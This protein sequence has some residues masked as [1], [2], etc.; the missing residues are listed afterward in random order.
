M[1]FFFFI[2]A[3]NPVN[4]TISIFVDGKEV[5]A[6][7][8]ILQ[9]RY[10]HCIMT[11]YHFST[12]FRSSHFWGKA[13][14]H[15]AFSWFPSIPGALGDRDR[16]QGTCHRHPLSLLT[17]AGDTRHRSGPRGWHWGGSWAALTSSAASCG[18]WRG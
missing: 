7:V 11:E 14:S 2:L 4:T 8:D 15:G 6:L 5:S 3:S 9:G 12:S 17:Q 1:Q 16:E 13:L 10:S 18:W